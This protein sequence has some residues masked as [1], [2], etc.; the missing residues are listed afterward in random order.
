MKAATSQSND[1]RSSGCSQLVGN[2]VP[3][4]PADAPVPPIPITAPSPP[5]LVPADGA[6]PPGAVPPLTL[7]PPVELVVPPKPPSGIPPS[8]S[9]PSRCD[10][11]TQATKNHP[12]P[13]T[14]SR[15]TLLTIGC[16]CPS[17]RNDHSSFARSSKLATFRA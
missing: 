9:P 3:P 14:P 17:A 11:P 5:E 6:P 10:S 7:C 13:Q 8:G 1:S 12:Q 15:R 4:I 2:P 16:M